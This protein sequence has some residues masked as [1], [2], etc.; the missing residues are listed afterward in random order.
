MIAKRPFHSSVSE[1]VKSTIYALRVFGRLFILGLVF[2][3]G[4][5]CG[6]VG[7]IVQ[8]QRSRCY[9]AK[10]FYLSDNKHLFYTQQVSPVC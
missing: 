6:S 7:G 2:I 1:N 5:T 3:L 4:I 8:T 9:L 10:R